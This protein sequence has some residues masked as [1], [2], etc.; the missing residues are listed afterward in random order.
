MRWPF[1]SGWIQRRVHREPGPVTLGRRRIFILPTRLG[2]VYA[3]LLVVMLLGA[4]NYSN[5]LA[6][7][8]T[9]LLASLGL[10]CMHHTHRNLLNLRVSAERA[11]PVFAGA[12]GA[13]P[14]TLSNPSRVPRFAVALTRAASGSGVDISANGEARLLMHTQPAKRG[15]L[16]APR[17]TLETGFPLGLF[18]AWAWVE[19]DVSC[20]VYPKP[21]DRAG[22]APRQHHGAGDAAAQR[23]GDEDF[24]SLRAYRAGDPIRRIHWKSGSGREGPMV[25]QFS[26]PAGEALWLDWGQLAGLDTEARLSRLCRWVL[27]ASQGGDTYGMRL[28][29]A[30]IEPG[31]G[32][33]HERRC[34]EALALYPHS[35]ESS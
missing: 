17:F 28:P 16:P 19:L 9:F 12:R 13:F 3:G 21:D 22:A 30:L 8:L 5:S 1:R 32:T 31:S 20:L 26:S 25:K 23:P 7:G 33:A 18:R 24:D 14:L 15:R 27:E 35:T 11:E 29:G 10:V 4:T 6:F 2:L 34:L